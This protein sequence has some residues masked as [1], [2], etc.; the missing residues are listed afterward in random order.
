MKVPCGKLRQQCETLV[1]ARLSVWC[2]QANNQIAPSKNF[3]L[4]DAKITFNPWDWCLLV[5]LL[6]RYYTSYFDKV[7][8]SVEYSNTLPWLLITHCTSS[9]FHDG[10]QC[11]WVASQGSRR[12]APPSSTE[13]DRVER[14]GGC[15]CQSMLSVQHTLHR[16][17]SLFETVGTHEFNLTSTT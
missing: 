15:R 5:M 8:V 13:N 9:L 1:W 16:L 14:G 6:K 4:K 7:W 3:F 10:I 12:A 11:S 2:L 17:F